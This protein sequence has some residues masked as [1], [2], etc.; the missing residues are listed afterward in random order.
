MLSRTCLVANWFDSIGEEIWSI[1]QLPA[2]NFSLTE[3]SKKIFNETD[4]SYFG[5]Q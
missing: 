3:K 2:L 4:N 1:N 5:A